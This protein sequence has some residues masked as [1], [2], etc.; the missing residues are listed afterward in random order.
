ML[1]INCL[2]TW[3]RLLGVIAAFL[4]PSTAMLSGYFAWS[5]FVSKALALQQTLVGSE[6]F[7]VGTLQSVKN[8]L[9]GILR[10]DVLSLSVLNEK[11]KNKMFPP[12]VPMVYSRRC[13]FQERSLEAM[14][15]LGVVFWPEDM[16]VREKDT[17]ANKAKLPSVTI[18]V[19]TASHP[20]TVLNSNVV[21]VPL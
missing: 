20:R 10:K 14:Y 12:K 19:F 16:P 1:K 9:L 21:L 15:A 17:L 6:K 2:L 5:S 7:I 18:K 13:D 8:S 4:N 3:S 11:T